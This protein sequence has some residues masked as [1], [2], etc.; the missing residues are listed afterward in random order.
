VWGYRFW[1]PVVYKIS[2]NMLKIKCGWQKF[3]DQTHKT[4]NSEKKVVGI[5]GITIG[6][7]MGLCEYMGNC[8]S[9]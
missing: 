5:V 2:A 9:W 6:Q 3:E 4:S 1:H 7:N 8:D